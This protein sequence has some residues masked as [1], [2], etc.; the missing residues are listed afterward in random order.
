MSD[1]TYHQYLDKG[2]IALIDHMGSDAAIVDAARKSYGSNPV[3]DKAKDRKLIFYLAAN[4]H[5]S[6]F[7]MVEFKFHLKI[8]I[9]V[10]RQ[11]VRHRTASLN[12]LSARY[13]EVPEEF[14]VPETIGVQHK[15][16]K[17]ASGDDVDDDV[18]YQ[19]QAIIHEA[20]TAS[21]NA[22]IQLLA[23]GVARETAREVLPVGYYTE[24]YWKIDL[25]NL[26]H[27]IKLRNSG[28]AQYEI[29]ALA[30][31]VGELIRPIVPIAY[32][33]FERHTL[34]PLPEE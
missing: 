31:Q 17:Q 22:Y 9:F 4:R 24:L 14:Y 18:M 7:E 27:F 34:K 33:A 8:P 10:A 25:H 3:R 23:L 11:L 15:T 1:T 32:E 20:H 5:T 12:E 30:Q 28:H 26:L 21:Y 13:V 29:R 6:P 19:A 16:N 2:F